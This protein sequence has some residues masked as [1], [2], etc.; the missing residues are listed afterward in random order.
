MCWNWASVLIYFCLRLEEHFLVI[1][2]SVSAS[3]NHVS[4][5]HTR[6]HVKGWGGLWSTRPL[7]ALGLCVQCQHQS[8]AGSDCWGSHRSAWPW[9]GV[10][11]CRRAFPSWGSSGTQL[12]PAESQCVSG[13]SRQMWIEHL[14][15]VHCY[16][17][18]WIPSL[19][20]MNS[21]CRMDSA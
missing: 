16:F 15:V 1:K 13:G 7:G 17:Q 6:A 11:G 21:P 14:R 19:R 3:L 20:Q 8:P 5:S 12:V 18:L 10:P 9:L 4:V 2:I